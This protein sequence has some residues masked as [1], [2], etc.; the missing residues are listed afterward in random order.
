MAGGT[1]AG[2]DRGMARAGGI[3]GGTE[4]AGARGMSSPCRD[5]L[6]LVQVDPR[7]DCR[8]RAQHPRPRAR[9]TQRQSDGHRAHRPDCIV[10]QV[11]HTACAAPC[12]PCRQRRGA[13]GD[14][15][16]VR[17]GERVQPAAVA[18]QRRGEQPRILFEQSAPVEA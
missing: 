12:E 13:R 15:P 14:D 16:V 4:M 3:A 5:A 1:G 6:L 8:A 10:R 17:Q 7:S 18:A 11:E 2:E 9:S